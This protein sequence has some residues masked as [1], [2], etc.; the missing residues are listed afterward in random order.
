VI[1]YAHGEVNPRVLLCNAWGNALKVSEENRDFGVIM[2]K[3][4]TPSRQCV[5]KHQ[6]S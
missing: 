2:H 4:S 3:Y 5:A 6:R 1:S